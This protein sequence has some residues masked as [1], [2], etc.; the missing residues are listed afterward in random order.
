MDDELAHKLKRVELEAKID[1]LRDR[2][3]SAGA[4]AKRGARI[5]WQAPIVLVPTF[6]GGMFSF[7]VLAI[8]GATATALVSYG[9]VLLLFGSLARRNALRALRAHGAELPEA[10]VVR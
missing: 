10:R 9:G 7:A 3:K 5:M 4:I 6:I 2:A 1:V 8:G